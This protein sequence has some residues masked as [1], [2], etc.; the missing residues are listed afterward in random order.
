MCT[1]QI[2]T[3]CCKFAYV[4]FNFMYDLCQQF[5]VKSRVKLFILILRHEQSHDISKYY[6]SAF[7]QVG[8]SCLTFK[9]S[10]DTVKPT[11]LTE[12]KETIAQEKENCHTWD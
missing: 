4:L 10:K 6:F 7:I 11:Q 2:G 3:K 12:T 1:H 5:D 8:Y 9:F